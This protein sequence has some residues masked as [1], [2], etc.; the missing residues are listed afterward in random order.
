MLITPKTKI[1][2]LLDAYPQL[3]SV[4]IEISP[5]FEKLKNPVLR[6]TVARVATIQQISVVGGID[7]DLI[8]NRL[9]SEVGQ[10]ET[11]TGDTDPG[12][13]PP[14][15]PEWFD[16]KKIRI[17][18]DATPIINAGGSPMDEVLRNARRLNH[19]EIFE[20][21]TPFIP[22]PILDMMKDMKFNIYCIQ[23]QNTVAS[24]INRV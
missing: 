22:A 23:G 7:V 3:E 15:P 12:Y 6:R 24:Y 21:R 1:G 17:R 13:T 8:I 2:E 5:V 11:V 19:G 18:F 10:S 16:E 14:S 20:L 9:R 4:L